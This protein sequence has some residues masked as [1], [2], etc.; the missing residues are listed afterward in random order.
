MTVI[1]DGNDTGA[2]EGADRRQLFPGDAFGDCARDKN[3]YDSLL[4]CALVN[5][6]HSAGI[7]DGGGSVWHANQRSETAPRGCGR[8]GSNSFFSSLAGLTQMNME[9]DQSR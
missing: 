2:F 5:Q 3:V 9:I 4:C 1:C 7:V 6:R 8:A